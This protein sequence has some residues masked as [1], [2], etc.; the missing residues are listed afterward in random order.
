MIMR[1]TESLPDVL[2]IDTWV[3][4]CRVFGRELEFEVMNIAVETARERGASALHARYVPTAKNIVVRDL[5]DRL[6]FTRI[7]S[8]EGETARWRLALDSY[9][10]LSTHIR[11]TPQP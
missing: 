5:Y 10:P 2:E 11:R 3:M 4:S 7:D 1:R 8:G 9:R 6:G